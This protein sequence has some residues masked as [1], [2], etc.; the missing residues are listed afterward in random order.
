MG[1]GSLSV[2]ASSPF[3]RRSVS[4]RMWTRLRTLVVRHL[5]R[6]RLDFLRFISRSRSKSLPMLSSRACV[7]AVCKVSQFSNSRRKRKG[8]RRRRIPHFTL[9]VSL[10]FPLLFFNNRFSF[11]FPFSNIRRFCTH[12]DTEKG[13]REKFISHSLGRFRTAPHLSS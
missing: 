7:H 6:R 5:R 4:A 9:L 12:T 2:L 11:N 10:L 1:R 3:A 13:E 8:R